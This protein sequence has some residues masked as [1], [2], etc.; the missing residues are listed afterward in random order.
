M[1]IEHDKSISCTTNMELVLH[2]LR[3]VTLYQYTLL[4]LYG[5]PNAR[6]RRCS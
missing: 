2:G 1:F 5:L 6:Q 3:I 4:N